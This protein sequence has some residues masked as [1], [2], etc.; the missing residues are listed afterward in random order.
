MLSDANNY[1]PAVIYKRLIHNAR[2]NIYAEF[3]D[4]LDIVLDLHWIFLHSKIFKFRPNINFRQHI[5]KWKYDASSA[6]DLFEKVF[7]LLPYV[8]EDKLPVVKFTNIGNVFSGEKLIV[9]YY[10]PN[11]TPHKEIRQILYDKLKIPFYWG[12]DKYKEPA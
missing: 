4:N 2:E 10:C 8:A 9:V 3:R 11:S 1:P 5:G 12:S 7:M 6:D